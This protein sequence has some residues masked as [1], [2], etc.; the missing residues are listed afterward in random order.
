MLQLCSGRLLKVGVAMRLMVL[1]FL[2]VG[3]ITSTMIVVRSGTLKHGTKFWRSDIDFDEKF[4]SIS[5]F[6]LF[7]LVWDSLQN[8]ISEITPSLKY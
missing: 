5:R 3:Y 6:A 4:K 8:E 2:R 7:F 1:A